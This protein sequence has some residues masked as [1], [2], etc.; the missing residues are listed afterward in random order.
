MNKNKTFKDIVESFINGDKETAEKLFHQY[1]VEQSRLI[2]ENAE[3]E[4]HIGGDMEDDLLDDMDAVD[5]EQEHDDLDSD[6]ADLAVDMIDD[7]EDEED[8]VDVDIESDD[9]EHDEN[10]DEHLEDKV[11]DLE[12][13]IHTIEDDLEALKKEFEEMM[14]DDED[15]DD[16]MVKESMHL[17]KHKQGGDMQKGVKHNNV[18]PSS[19]PSHEKLDAKLGAKNSKAHSSHDL[20]DAPKVKNMDKMKNVVKGDSMEKLKESKTTKRTK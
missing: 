9:E 2:L 11:E 5:F 17:L 4:D 13:K 19:N 15:Y 10:H 8:E 20:E 3:K 1:I 7:M 18:S 12:D 6:A 14:S 16:E